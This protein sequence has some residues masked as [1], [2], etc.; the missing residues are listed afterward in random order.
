M[1]HFAHYIKRTV[2][3][4]VSQNVS[5]MLPYV[6]HQQKHQGFELPKYHSVPTNSGVAS[7]VDIGIRFGCFRSFQVL[8]DVWRL[9]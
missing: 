6:E 7:R 2:V 3:E 8:G 1:R 4:C 9:L 5:S